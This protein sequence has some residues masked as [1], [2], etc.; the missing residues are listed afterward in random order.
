M[1]RASTPGPAAT[2]ER[3]TW[4]CSS[5]LLVGVEDVMLR[6]HLHVAGLATIGRRRIDDEGVG[7]RVVVEQRVSPAT[8][9][10]KPLAVLL[11]HEGLG[12]DIGHVNDEG[13]V[14]AL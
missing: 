7:R 11:H 2:R 6:F 8:G 4:R 12:K 5:T 13:S 14:G 1:Q 3:W 10:W 9:L